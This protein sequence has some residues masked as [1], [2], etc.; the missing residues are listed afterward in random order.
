[1]WR[2]SSCGLSA[3]D[4]GLI[5]TEI[6]TSCHIIG[7]RKSIQPKP[8]HSLPASVRQS[9]TECRLFKHLLKTFQY[10]ETAAGA[11]VTFA[12]NA[13][14]VNRF[15]YLFTASKAVHN[16]SKQTRTFSNLHFTQWYTGTIK[17]HTEIYCK[18][19]NLT[20]ILYKNERE[21]L[22]SAIV[23]SQNVKGLH[24]HGIKPQK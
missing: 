18:Q 11:L 13:L 14:G 23:H 5:P 24:T 8:I 2:Q 22:I 19:T 1:M 15:T 10:C 12:F 16:A 4:L 7:T 21:K 17:W 9:D 6:H 3:D 20:I